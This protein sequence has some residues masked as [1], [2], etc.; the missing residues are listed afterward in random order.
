MTDSDQT[1]HTPP[2][3]ERD[4][5]EDTEGHSLLSGELHAQLERDRARSTESY[6]RDEQ[7]RRAIGKP[8]QGQ[9]IRQ[10]LFG[11]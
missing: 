1:P 10:R 5:D 7:N 2:I 8:R 11:R 9:G 6:V 4:V 3:P